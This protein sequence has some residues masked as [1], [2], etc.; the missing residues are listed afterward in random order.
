MESSKAMMNVFPTQPARTLLSLALAIASAGALSLAGCKGREGALAL[1]SAT[2]S[3]AQ[4]EVRTVKVNRTTASNVIRATGATA[5]RS[6]TK[7][8]PTVPGVVQS[9][10]VRE[11]DVVKKGQVLALLDQRQFRLTLRQAQAAVEAA[12]VG[13]Q[14]TT[15]E[16]ERF[17][18]LMKEDA[19][20]RAQFDQVM[21]HYRSALVGLK[22]AQ[23]ALDMA[24]K[25]LSDTVITSPYNGVVVKKMASLGD[26]ATSM[27]P[28]VLLI[29]M[30]ISTLDLNVSLAEPDLPAVQEGAP[31]EAEFPSIGRTVQAKVSRIIRTIDPMT[32]SF[33]AIVEVP[34][35]DLTL[36]AGL[37]ARVKITTSVS[38]PRLLLASEAVIDEGNGT[39]IVFLSEGGVAKR[40]EVRVSS[41]A[42]QNEVE[43]LT[44]LTG[45]EE[46]VLDASGLS[47]GDTIAVKVGA[48]APTPAPAKVPDP[49]A[50][51]APSAPEAAR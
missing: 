48:S 37:F 17:E 32:S 24:K 4:R 6:T 26:Y 38:R 42:G 25:A 18:R 21:D 43:I 13:I 49:A 1:P 46:V 35:A 2:A 16:K 47:D 14:A 50:A 34:N 19:A 8:M 22:Q 33:T 7:I 9:F 51:P 36:K 31:V 39:Y 30:E 10:P 41:N 15:R 28:T 3:T 20:A 40:R 27:P 12:Q 5:A 23:V 29:L 11:G 45:S 44:G